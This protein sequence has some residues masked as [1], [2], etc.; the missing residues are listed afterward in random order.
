MSFGVVFL[1]YYFI[2]SFYFYYHDV[3]HACACV[4]SFSLVLN[5]DALCWKIASFLQQSTFGYM[6]YVCVGNVTTSV[7]MW[8]FL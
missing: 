1:D 6:L 4:I 5:G 8:S 7:F 3:V 2:I